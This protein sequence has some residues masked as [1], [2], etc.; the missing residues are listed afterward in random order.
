MIKRM[1]GISVVEFAND[2]PYGFNQD[3]FKAI[4]END[5]E[6]CKKFAEELVPESSQ[7]GVWERLDSTYWSLGYGLVSTD[8]KGVISIYEGD[9]V[10]EKTT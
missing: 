9:L 5:I 1:Y 6:V 10:N 7:K 8:P 4:L 3:Y 2:N